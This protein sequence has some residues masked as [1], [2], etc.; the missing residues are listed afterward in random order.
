MPDTLPATEVR[1][2][3][4]DLAGVAAA[5]QVSERQVRRLIASGDFGPAALRIGRRCVRIRAAELTAWV[6]SGAAPRSRWRWT[7]K[8][9]E[10][11]RCS[12]R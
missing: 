6:A 4:L 12:A 10:G 9:S 8:E 3:L 11:C 7:P 2:L 5:L 1:P